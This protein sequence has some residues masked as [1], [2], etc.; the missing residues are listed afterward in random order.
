MATGV[1]AETRE[2][3]ARDE[4]FE[5][6]STTLIEHGLGHNFKGIGIA[7]EIIILSSDIIADLPIRLHH[8]R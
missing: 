4:L 2:L 3:P 1:V 8:K 5:S 6:S 7:D